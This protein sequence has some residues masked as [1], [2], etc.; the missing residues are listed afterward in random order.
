MHC[1]YTCTVGAWP[2]RW[3]C[4]EIVPGHQEIACIAR[5]AGA[6]VGDKAQC[7]HRRGAHLQAD[8]ALHTV[9]Q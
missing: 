1:A 7:M 2:V 4:A 9:S 5:C 8:T 6:G 3:L